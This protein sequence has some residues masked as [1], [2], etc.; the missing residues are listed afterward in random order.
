[1]FSNHNEIDLQI[2]N[3]KDIWNILEYLEIKQRIPKKYQKRNFKNHKL[4]SEYFYQMATTL[5][6]STA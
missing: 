5:L 1:M 4:Q 6:V 2:N 3:K